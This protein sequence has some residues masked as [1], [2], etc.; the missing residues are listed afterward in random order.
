MRL[1]DPEA[2]A[3]LKMNLRLRRKRL[4]PQRYKDDP[5]ASKRSV[6]VYACSGKGIFWVSNK[7]GLVDMLLE[8]LT[9]YE[10]EVESDT[11]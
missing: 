10:W 6:F 2:I 4:I 1:T 7:R 3:A 9:S 8:D 11:F 5:Y